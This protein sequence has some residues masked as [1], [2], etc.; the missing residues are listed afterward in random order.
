MNV[1]PSKS[2]TTFE[3]ACYCPLYN[4]SLLIHI[5]ANDRDPAWL[6]VVKMVELGLSLSLEK[7]E[8][9]ESTSIS[10][11]LTQ[12]NTFTAHLS[13]VIDSQ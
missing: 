3:F 9:D 7:L 13:M 8:H 4:A 6:L 1:D 10:L 5:Q 2:R 12:A 11:R